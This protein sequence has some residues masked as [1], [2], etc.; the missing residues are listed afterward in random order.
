MNGKRSLY[1]VK[2]IDAGEEFTMENVRSIRPSYGLPTQYF[3]KLVGSISK[4]N[5]KIGD[6]IVLSDIDFKDS[7]E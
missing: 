6:R 2:A 7:D 5:L 4:R 3:E 1:C